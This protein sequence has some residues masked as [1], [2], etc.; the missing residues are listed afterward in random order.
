MHI[1][2]APNAFK[3]SLD[4]WSVAR[5]IEKGLHDS[6]LPCTTE[7]FPIGDGGDGTGDLILEKCNGREISGQVLDPLGRTITATFGLIDDGKTAVIEMA[8][9]SGLRLLQKSELNPL[10]ALSYGTGQQIKAALD[11]GVTR[12]VITMGGSATV[13]GGVGILMALGAQFLDANGVSLRNPPGTLDQL[14]AID[15][16][17][18]DKR[19]ANCEI[20]VLCDVKNNLLGRAGAAAVFGPQKGASSDQVEILDRGLKNFSEVVYAAIGKDMS[21]ITSGGTAGGA[22][23]GLFALINAKLVNGIDYFLELTGFA[24]SLKKADAAV[25][26]EGS[27]DEQTLHGKGPYGVAKRAKEADLPV[28]GLAG[29][30]PLERTSGLN[31]YFD[32]LLSIGNEPSDLKMAFRDTEANLIRVSEVIGNL[33]HNEW[34][35]E[36]SIKGKRRA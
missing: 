3:G 24:E 15:I 35:F 16:S 7:C 14:H 22:A 23:A 1:L 30:V 29:R 32:V 21:T 13:D 4:A 6:R 20:V 2:I 8:N 18:M 36:S 27:L 34:I 5:A 33:L 9:A 28:I 25:T 12:V 26:G 17:G 10:I 11:R 19:L 31:E